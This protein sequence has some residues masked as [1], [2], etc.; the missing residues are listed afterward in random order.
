MSREQF[1]A[2]IEEKVGLTDDERRAFTAELDGRPSPSLSSKDTN[3][4]GLLADAGKEYTLYEFNAGHLLHLDL[5]RH[6]HNLPP[7]PNQP[8]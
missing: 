5:W 6:K 1:F 3:S 8:G 4:G 7:K 2:L